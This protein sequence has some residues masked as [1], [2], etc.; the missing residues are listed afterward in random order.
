MTSFGIDQL[1]QSNPNWKKQRIALVTNQ[2]ATTATYIPSRKA[3][4]DAGF[5][6]CRLFSPEH[7]LDIRGADGAKMKDGTD[8][9][10]GLPVISLYSEKLAPAAADLKG[11]DLVLFDIPDIGCRFYTYLWTLTHVL[12][13]C[14]HYGK[15]LVILDR[16]NPISGNLALAEGPVLDEQHCT[17]FIGRWAIPLR[18]SCTF[19]ELALYFNEIKG[20]EASVE[21]ITCNGW[22]R[23]MF[24]PDWQLQFVPTSPAMNN[25]QSALLYPG[26]GL[27]EATNISE[28]RGTPIPF[29]RIG[30]PWFNPKLF[31]KYFKV[32]GIRTQAVTFTPTESKYQQEPCQGIS[33]SVAAPYQIPSVSIG[34]LLIKQ[35]YD[36]F[37]RDFQWKPYP[38]LVNPT[39][40]QHLDKLLGIPDTETLF[41]YTL[42]DF[43]KTIRQITDTGSWQQA[44]SPFLL[45]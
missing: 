36:L 37:P 35:L 17:S 7:G 19:G 44:I 38:T 18:H 27:L 5:N 41:D 34:L 33:I 23:N 22:K 21:V 11:I 28:G 10:T 1:L 4:L 3:L 20:L 40:N 39:G 6:I 16:P 43:E 25:F 15:K 29:S 14:G 24:Q 12:E 2:A 32:P 9:L 13:S 31:A 30:A 42:S 26:L 45:Y 8:N